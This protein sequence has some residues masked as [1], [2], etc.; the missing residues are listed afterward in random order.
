MV[1]YYNENDPYCAEWLRN[2]VL[3]GL[4]PEGDVDDRSISDVDPSDL[5]GYDQCHF[6]CGIAG[7][8]LALQ[9]A[10]WP[11]DREVW[12]GSCPCQGLSNAGKRLA[13]ADPR[14]LWPDFFA[15]IR[16]R[17]PLRITG[18]QVASKLGRDWFDGVRA[19]LES[20]AY[21][22]GIVDIPA[23]SVNAPHIRNRLWWFADAGYVGDD[24]GVGCDARLAGDGAGQVGPGSAHGAIADRSNTD[25]SLVN[26]QSI[27]WGE[28]QSE[29][30]LRSGWPAFGGAGSPSS[31]MGDGNSARRALCGIPGELRNTQLG[32]LATPERTGRPSPAGYWDEYEWIACADGKQRRVKPGVHLLVNGL[33][34]RIPRIR[35]SGNAIVPIL[36]AEIIK[37]WMEVAP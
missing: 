32:T 18:E 24:R 13:A 17:R 20:V 6:F 34:A 29:S 30:E 36:A 19:D 22:S 16:A 28:G 3:V 11:D 37:A 33:S 31:D 26:G 23:C 25:V 7:W 27:G 14:H 9:I 15:L 2:L 1:S 4:L 8:P 10:G 21:V 5:I 12:T 35:A